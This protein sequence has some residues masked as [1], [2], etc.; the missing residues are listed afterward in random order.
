MRGALYNTLSAMAVQCSWPFFLPMQYFANQSY[1]SFYAIYD[2]CPTQEVQVYTTSSSISACRCN[3]QLLHLFHAYILHCHS[4]GTAELH[5]SWT[6][7]ICRYSAM[8]VHLCMMIL[9]KELNIHSVTVCQSIKQYRNLNVEVFNATMPPGMN[10][11]G[12]VLGRQ[13]RC[14][15]FEIRTEWTRQGSTVNPQKGG[16]CYE[17]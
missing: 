8:C 1:G 15:N 4:A 10:A 16:A 3:S 7:A 5:S 2:Y 13:S 12:E 6:P 9:T 17:V 11:F 14:F